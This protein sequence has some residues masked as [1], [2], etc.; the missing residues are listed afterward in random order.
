MP[1]LTQASLSRRQ[2]LK[3]GMGASLLLGS[4]GL[5][6]TLSGCSPSQPA[7]SFDVLRESDLEV[8]RALV[9]ALVGEHPALNAA[10]V[11]STLRQLDS[12]LLHSSPQVQKDLHDLLGMLSLCLLRGPLTGIWGSWSNASAQQ[13]ETF[14]QGWRDSRVQLLRQGYVALSQLL[15]MAWYAQPMSW[16]ETGYPGPPQL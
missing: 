2:L 9:P 13:I 12:S 6:A 5:A 8:L 7:G 10:T 16:A 15:L 14:L 1:S 11:E 3:L 4:A